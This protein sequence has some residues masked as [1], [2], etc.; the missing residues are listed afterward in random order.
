MLRKRNEKR[1]R[2]KRVVDALL[3]LGSGHEIRRMELEWEDDVNGKEVAEVV[4]VQYT[5]QPIVS[6]WK[7]QQR[8]REMKH[9]RT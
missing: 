4:A 3:V 7:K 9:G 1:K 8:R 6:E 5:L 2:W